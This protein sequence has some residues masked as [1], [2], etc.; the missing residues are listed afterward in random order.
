LQIDGYD[1]IRNGRTVYV[2]AANV[3]DKNNDGLPDFLNT[4]IF[5]ISFN[6]DAQDATFDAFG[7]LLKNLKFNAN[8]PNSGIC[9]KT[10][11][12]NCLN[13]RECPSGEYCESQK[14]KVIRDVKR[15][16]D[17]AEIKIKLDNYKQQNGVYPNLKSGTYLANKSL[18][19]WPS[20][21]QNLSKELG[22]ALPVDPINQLGECPGYDSATCWN[23]VN[24]K[25]ATDLSKL[26]LPTGSH[27][28]LYS[29]DNQGKT[30]SYCVQIESGYKNIENFNCF[31]DKK[32]NNPP[33][34]KGI[35]LTGQPKQ[36][37]S[38]YVSIYD[39][40]G[41]PIK[42]TIDL[43]SPSPDDWLKNGWQ[44]ENGLNKFSIISS[45]GSGQKKIYAPKTGDKRP[46][47]YYKIKLTLDDGQKEKNS[48]YT[49]TYD[50]IINPFPANLNKAKKTITIGQSDT[51]YMD[52]LDSNSD[53][54]TELFFDNASY[55][56]TA[57]SRTELADNG[58][59]LSGNSLKENFN[60]TQR[61]GVYTVNV[62]SQNLNTATERVESSF[63][64]DIANN[65]PAFQELTATFSN[66]TTKKCVSG[67]CLISIDN[68]EPAT[69]K[70]KGFDQDGHKLTY[71]LIDNFNNKLTINSTTGIISG[72]EKLNS[73]QLTEQTFNISTKISDEYCENSSEAECSIIYSFD[74]LVKGYCSITD[75]KSTLQATA[76]QT[77][78]IR[79]TGDVLNTG[80]N[81]NDCLMVG[82]SSADI[83]FIGQAHNQ[84]IALV[85]DLSKSMDTNV[86]FDNV[87]ES[88]I[89]RLKKALAANET[90]F[91]DKIYNIISNW[92]TE[93]SIKIGL[94]A[95]NKTIV[96]YQNLV[97]L[98]LP[99]S[100]ANLKNIINSY[101]TDYQTNTLAALNKA[102]E[103]LKPITDPNTKKV[104]ILMSDGIPGIDGYSSFTP[105]CVKG[106][107]D[108]GG[109]Y[110][111][112]FSCCQK[113]YCLW[114]LPADS[115]DCKYYEL[116]KTCAHN[117]QY[118]CCNGKNRC[119]DNYC[120][121]GGTYPYCNNCPVTT[122]PH[123]S[124]NEKTD[125]ERFFSGLFKIKSAQAITT[126][127]K[128]VWKDCGT[129]YPDFKCGNDE[130]ENC[131]GNYKI[132]C[133]L[134]DDVNIEASALKNLGTSIYTIYYDT[135]GT[136]T[137]KQQMCDWSSNNGTNCNNNEYAFSGSDIDAMINKVLGRVITKPKNV[138][139][140]SY[141]IIDS[142]P[143]SLVSNV[144]GAEIGGLTCGA[145]E[146]TITYLDD[147]YLEFS[148]LKINYCPAKLHP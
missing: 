46:A 144:I 28:Y 63:T 86:I 96:S 49:Q 36:V 12:I 67:K 50:V 130:W 113:D 34:V 32:N 47:G 5:I 73:Q 93:Y 116:E 95:Y 55:N 112:C 109:T 118:Y 145:I 9:N 14:A 59:V 17:L 135:S 56:N 30:A 61:T 72:F 124:Y 68:S 52:G 69:V 20:W 11:A 40:D 139:V 18:S 94:I 122:Q 127:N 102:E 110:P 126:Q 82:T 105:Q 31:E 133:D 79:K 99:G 147:G 35:N 141:N 2:N 80:I 119:C 78:T 60:P 64:C 106:T 103:M 25:F 104:V 121:C 142:A 57:L 16:A 88:A 143:A 75:P 83:K 100:L 98:A 77:F 3:V 108:C 21:Q 8:L 33:V 71:S 140:G 81:L 137:P 76:S 53:P 7:Q 23:E 138:K 129:L 51:I 19:T 128:C 22:T 148:N 10:T 87:S 65:P 90:G 54:I 4:N 114:Y 84:V 26:I 146:P 29:G 89:S 62:Y 120:P 37:F 43:I 13:D 45:T 101:S 117:T 41:D 132:N 111:D 39:L 136:S 123:S 134:S 107:C 24:K 15:L 85:S 1:A 91:L 27:I 97:N 38:G 131:F 66:N 70:I 44:W 74:L 125:W 42:T 92:P 6:Q 48:I 115:A 58:F